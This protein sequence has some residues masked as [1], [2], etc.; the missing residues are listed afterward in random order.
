MPGAVLFRFADIGVVWAIVEVSERDLGAVAEG[1]PAAVRVRSY[2]DRVFAGKV[3]LIYPQLNPA[4]AHRPRPHR[5][6]QSGFPRPRPDMYADAIIDTGR[7]QAV[8]SVPEGALIDSG[9]RRVV[10]VDK[11]EGRAPAAP[12]EDRASRRGLRPEI[13]AGVS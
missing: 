10:I 3:A 5:A 6:C 12:G 11:G 8:L 4:D 2:P 1:Q 7:G 13:R 9:D